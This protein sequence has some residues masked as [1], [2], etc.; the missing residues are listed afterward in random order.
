[1]NTMEAMRVSIHAFAPHSSVA[2]YVCS[3]G[4]ILA[5]L[6]AAAAY[7][8]FFRKEQ[9]KLPQ[10]QLLRIAFAAGPVPIYV[11]L[12]LAPLDPDLGKALMEQQLALLLAG[13]YGLF[14]T[15]TDIKVLAK[16]EGGG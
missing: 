15:V 12:P 9:T 1:M 6:A 10:G 8:R 5:A 2:I 13:M 4:L 14:W 16:G 11:L 7:H 3:A